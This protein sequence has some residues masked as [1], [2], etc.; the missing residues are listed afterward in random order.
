MALM[1]TTIDADGTVGAEAVLDPRVCECCQTSA[2]ATSDGLLVVYRNRSD[3]E[4]YSMAIL[5]SH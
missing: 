4:M 2:A 5:I 3:E 1:H